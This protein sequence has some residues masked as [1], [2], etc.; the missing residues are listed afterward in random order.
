MSGYITAKRFG[1]ESREKE[2]SIAVNVVVPIATR[3]NTSISTCNSYSIGAIHFKF[4]PTWIYLCR[5][6][7]KVAV[8]FEK[9]STLV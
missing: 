5:S 2:Y 4:D 9:V 7:Q 8:R 1:D 6:P 3:G